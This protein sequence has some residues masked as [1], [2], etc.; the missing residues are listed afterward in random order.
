[1]YA[2][3]IIIIVLISLGIS[4]WGYYRIPDKEKN[5]REFA[6][7]GIGLII[8]L[9]TLIVP[10]IIPQEATPI[11]VPELEGKIKENNKL[12]TEIAEKDKVILNTAKEKEKLLS[13]V[14][15]LNEK[16]FADIRSTNLVIDGLKHEDKVSLSF[17]NNSMYLK[18]DTVQ[19]ILNQQIT[20]DETTET[21]YIGNNGKKVTKEALEDNYSMLYNGKNYISLDSVD[22][23]SIKEPKIAGIEMTQGFILED[24]KI[25]DSYVLLRLDGKYS[26]IEFDA[27]MLDNT[28]E[29]NIED[30][31]IKIEL[32]GK[33][34][35]KEKIPADIATT[36][37]KFDVPETRTLKISLN[38]SNAIFGFYNVIFNK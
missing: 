16:N 4:L 11:I 38:N 17:V 13:Q 12:K 19:K 18:Q 32:D 24:S 29:Y 27:G 21:I 26:S 23:S 31:D 6:K 2:S 34:K 28:S 10:L 1:M 37:Y 33:E 22:N 5:K 35:Y 25:D 7:L 20:Y 8:P 14:K 3:I 9:F 36:H 30:G 15:E